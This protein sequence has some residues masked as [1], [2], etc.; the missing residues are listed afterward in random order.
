MKRFGL[1]NNN[2]YNFSLHNAQF[3]QI[4]FLNFKKIYLSVILCLSRSSIA[5]EHLA[6]FFTYFCIYKKFIC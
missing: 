5:F 6:L 3:L 1:T 4:F 2:T